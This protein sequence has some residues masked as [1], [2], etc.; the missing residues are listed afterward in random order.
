MAALARTLLAPGRR[1]AWPVLLLF[2]AG[3]AAPL[4]TVL[5]FSFAEPK[6]FSIW[7]PPTLENYR[8]IRGELKQYDVDLADRPEVIAVSKGE[9]PG[10]AEVRDKLA[11]ETGREVFLFSSVTG[12]GLSALMQRTYALLTEVRAAEREAENARV[13][14]RHPE[15]SEGSSVSI[16]LPDSSL[17][18][19]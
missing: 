19:E 17:R 12:E 6:S 8:T 9:L 14:R 5:L 18:S 10:A 11:A 13:R 3:F 2:L 16:E 7:H 15:Q 1:H 4:L